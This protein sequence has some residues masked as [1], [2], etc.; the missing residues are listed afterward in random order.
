MPSQTAY[1]EAQRMNRLSQDLHHHRWFYFALSLAAI[2]WLL[3]DMIVPR[4][5]LFVAGDVFYLSYLLLMGVLVFTPGR[6]SFGA[7]QRS[8][9]REQYL[10]RLPQSWLS[11]LASFQYSSF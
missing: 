6:T 7:E 10:L 4:L 2:A 8:M 11:V 3:T 9:M 1:L 5:R